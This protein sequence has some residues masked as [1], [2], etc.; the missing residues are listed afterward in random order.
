MARWNNSAISCAFC[1]SSQF[2]VPPKRPVFGE[3]R[4]DNGL[5]GA[6]FFMYQPSSELKKIGSERVARRPDSCRASYCAVSTSSGSQ[7]LY[8]LTR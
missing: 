7:R 6:T 2:S 3:D 1:N 4:S 8:V 5:A